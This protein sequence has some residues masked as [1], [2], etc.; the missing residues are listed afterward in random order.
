MGSQIPNI[1]DFLKQ[2]KGLYHYLKLVGKDLLLPSFEE[3]NL[4]SLLILVLVLTA[5]FF[6]LKNEK[7]RKAVYQLA[8]VVKALGFLVLFIKRSQAILKFISSLRDSSKSENSKKKR[9]QKVKMNSKLDFIGQTFYFNYPIHTSQHHHI[10]L[11]PLRSKMGNKIEK[12][13]VILH[14]DK[15]EGYTDD[16]FVNKKGIVTGEENDFLLCELIK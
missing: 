3:I 9:V 13:K 11:V 7:T 15:D 6:S 8:E 5:I 1:D 4:T 14:L 12:V 10:Y 2:S 16:E